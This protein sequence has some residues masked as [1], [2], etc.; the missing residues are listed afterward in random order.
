MTRIW[1]TT[2]APDYVGIFILLIIWILI[3]NLVKPFHRLFFLDDHAISYPHTEHERVTSCMSPNPSL[4]GNTLTLAAMS[5]VYGFFVP[6]LLLSIWNLLH[7]RSS[8]F[9]LQASLI[10]LSISALVT[11][12]ITDTVKNLVGRP[13][14]DLLA[15]CQP[16]RASLQP[17]VPLSIDACTAPHDASLHDGWR[18]FPS[19]HSSFSFAG[20]GYLSFFFAGQLRIFRP[21]HDGG[22][23]DL[24]RAMLC[25]IPL[26][27]AAFVALSRWEDYRHDAIDISTGSILGFCTAYWSYRRYWP[28]LS[29][30]ACDEPYP[31]PNDG[32]QSATWARVRDEEEGGTNV[33]HQLQLV[34][35]VRA[36]S[37]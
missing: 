32:A 30:Q 24:V 36:T 4:N 27:G 8:I 10:S 11:L 18:S 21:A 31:Q 2:Q 14:P 13:R 33:G 20:L 29:S 25:F 26:V 5:F 1:K 37:N 15:R 34:E 35:R 6:F 7:P 16:D 9:K 17:G 19:G 12:C 22:G 3:V 28:R 23:R